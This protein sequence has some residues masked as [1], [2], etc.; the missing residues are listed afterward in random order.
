MLNTFKE[1]LMGVLGT[2]L[3]RPNLRQG[4]GLLR[5]MVRC[6]MKERKIEIFLITILQFNYDAD[7]IPFFVWNLKSYGL[8]LFQVMTSFLCKIPK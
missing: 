2:K 3:G 8:F 6:V 7:F 4:K 1:R 5:Q